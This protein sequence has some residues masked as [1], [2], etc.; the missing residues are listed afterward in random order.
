MATC[1]EVFAEKG[2]LHSLQIPDGHDLRHQLSV[3]AGD[4][5]GENFS[6]PRTGCDS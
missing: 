6:E 2:Q 1:S 5:K 3:R 4:D